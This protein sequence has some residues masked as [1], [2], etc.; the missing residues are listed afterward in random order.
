MPATS[1][2]QLA[3]PQAPWLLQQNRQCLVETK[4]ARIKIGKSAAWWFTNLIQSGD[5]QLE[6]PMKS[7]GRTSKQNRMFIAM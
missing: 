3:D 1:V 6:P 5:Q 7:V 4:T 2:V